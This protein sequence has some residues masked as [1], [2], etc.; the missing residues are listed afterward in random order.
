MPE[1]VTGAKGAEAL[2]RSADGTVTYLRAD[3]EA[4]LRWMIAT[5]GGRA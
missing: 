4:V 2:W 1:L 5:P 3:G